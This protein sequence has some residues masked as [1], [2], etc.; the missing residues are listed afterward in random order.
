[1][2][3]AS[4]DSGHDWGGV[5]F[6]RV[7]VGTTTVTISFPS[8]PDVEA[9]ISGEWFGYFAPPGPDNGRLADATK[10]TAAS[11]T[12]DVA[13]R[14]NTGSAPIAWHNTRKAT[15]MSKT[16]F[17]SRTE[18]DHIRPQWTATD[19]TDRGAVTVRAAIYGLI[20]ILVGAIL[21][22][23]A[24]ANIGGNW[25]TS[26]SIGSL[27]GYEATAWIGAAVGGIIIGIAAL[28]LTQRRRSG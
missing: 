25:F 2:S 20:G 3:Y 18:P 14:S 11:P 26:F 15:H 10:V 6:G 12:G 21:G 4:E 5:A 7:P 24:G 27:H 17:T 23:I 22:F 19:E 1:M 13:S 16:M 8:G 28:W 9:T